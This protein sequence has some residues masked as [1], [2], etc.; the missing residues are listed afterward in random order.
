V[1]EIAQEA[2]RAIMQVYAKPIDVTHKDDKSPVTDADMP[3]KPSSCA[4]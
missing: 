3:P 2:G 1:T 4:D